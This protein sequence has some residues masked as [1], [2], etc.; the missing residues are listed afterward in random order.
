MTQEPL[1]V[2]QILP[3]LDQEL[4]R[5]PVV[6]EAPP[7]AG[8]S[9]ALPLFLLK[10]HDL[11]ESQL[12]I[13]VQPRRLAAVRI[14]HYLA[15]QLGEPVGQQVGYQVRQERVMGDRTRL[16]VITDGILTRWLQQDPELS[17][18]GLVIF[19]EFHERSLHSDLSLALTLETRELREDLRLLIMSA[20]LPGSELAAW[21]TE[22]GHPANYLVCAGRRFPVSL[23][24]RPPKH[25]ADWLPALPGVIREALQAAKQGVL[26]F[27]PGQREM[28]FLRRQLQC[29]ADVTLHVLYG[30]L[31]LAAQQAALEPLAQGRK[32]VLS[33]N[34]A[35]TS[36]TI[37]DIDVVVD[38]GRER[39]AEYHP[40][41]QLTQLQTRMIAAA[42]AEQRAGR[43]GRTQPGHCYRLWPESQQDRLTS[44][45]T[46]A[47]AREDLSQLVLE[48]RQWGTEPTALTWFTPPSSRALA[49]AEEQLSVLRLVTRHG[50]TATGQQVAQLGTEPWLAW[51]LITARQHSSGVA[52]WAAL[53]VAWQEERHGPATPE[54]PDLLWQLSRQQE[55]Y[56]RTWR[57]FRYWCRRLQLNHELSAE[58]LEQLLPLLLRARP[59]MLGQ[60][61]TD[62]KTGRLATGLGVQL[63]EPLA[64]HHHAWVLD[65]QLSEHQQR[66]TATHYWEAP[67]SLVQQQPMARREARAQWQGPKGRLVRVAVTHWYQ[68]TLAETELT[69]TPTAG[70][71]TTA[72]LDYL[73]NR[74]PQ[75]LAQPEVHSWLERLRLWLAL[76]D[77][78]AQPWSLAGLQ[79]D[80]QHWAGAWLSSMNT[81]VEVDRWSLLPA[82]KQ[83]LGYAREQQ[84][85][86]D[87]PTHW[88]A[89]SGRRHPIR[90]AAADQQAIVELKLQEV[91]GEPVTPRLAREQLPL[92]MALLS[93]AGRLLHQTRDLASF[94][95]N[96]YPEVRKEMRGRYPKHP[97]PE[98]PTQAVATHLTN[99][100]WQRHG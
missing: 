34:I 66:A 88:E 55:Q 42:S 96:A 6:L 48:A 75:S 16:V 47:L 62:S 36:L 80:L 31:S 78:D 26:V 41:Y 90:Y 64:T 83:R 68:L 59:A 94:W 74:L 18:V 40:G 70:E 84:L 82:L 29:P 38:S 52:T 91:F 86:A 25:V 22:Q 33:T 3:Q 46:P 54:V 77:Q 85:Q 50:L 9:T 81:Q 67:L 39:Q 27:V 60:F 92:T 95:Q 11:P 57:R 49:T 5:N 97:W 14:A 13:L 79:E 43:A 4:R 56:P 72:L 12:I 20:T 89:P 37:P 7:G 30:G 19:D 21:L 15:T 8:K 71:R 45:G 69:G 1:P 23:H 51:L 17:S 93:P 35:E 73:A 32:L 63:A 44:Y 61:R 2:T 76:R 65:C 100:A 87:L 24:Y 53:L 28:R 10:E 58:Q 99:K 98:D